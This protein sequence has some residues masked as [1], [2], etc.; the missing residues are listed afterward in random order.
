VPWADARVHVYSPL[1]KYAAGVFEGIRGYWNE[2]RQQMYVFRLPE[3]MER[4][5][6]SQTAMRFDKIFDNDYVAEQILAVLRANECRENVHVRAMVYVDGEGDMDALGP[7]SLTITAIS[8]PSPDWVRSGCRAQVSSWQRVSDR[9]M[10]LRIKANANYQNARLACV[11]AKLDGYDTAIFLNDRGKLAEGPGMCLFLVRNGVPITP[12]VTSDILES[13]TRE[14]VLAL[15]RE[16]LQV[17]PLEREMDRSEILA[18]DEAFFCGTGWEITPLVNVD[19]TNIGNG[20]PGPLTKALQSAY[21][22]IVHGRDNA[23]A[24]WRTAVYSD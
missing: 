23:Y 10:P 16:R 21:F 9:A 2:D 22:D 11:Q 14:T 6:Y 13:I 17:E 19:G 7:T 15:C 12:T 8:R 24:G 1:A 18:A 4:L 5:R 3:H 20:T